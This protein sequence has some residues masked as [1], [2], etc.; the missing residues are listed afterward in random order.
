MNRS[1][2]SFHHVA[3]APSGID[4][5][6]AE[7]DTTSRDS[8]V[9][10]TLDENT[11]LCFSSLSSE[12]QGHLAIESMEI[13]DST[14]KRSS[15]GIPFGRQNSCNKGL[16]NETCTTPKVSR[17][18]T[19]SLTVRSSN[20][21]NGTRK[22]SMADAGTGDEEYQ[23]KRERSSDHYHLE[24]TGESAEDDYEKLGGDEVMAEPMFEDYPLGQESTSATT[25]AYVAF[26][27]PAQPKRKAATGSLV[28]HHTV[29]NVR[30]DD[31][32][33]E[34]LDEHHLRV[35]YHLPTTQ[36]NCST[37]F[38]R[39]GAK[40]MINVLTSMTEEAFLKKFI[41]IDCRYPF[42]YQAGH[43]KH[44][45]N[46]YDPEYV[47][48]M[49]YSSPHHKL[50]DRIPIFYCEFSQ[51]RGPS[52]ANALRK[53]DRNLNFH[54]YPRCSFEEMY[55]L[56]KG[57]REFHRITTLNKVTNLC[58]PRHAYVEMN[59]HRYSD[60]LRTYQQHKRLPNATVRRFVEP[61]STLSLTGKHPVTI[62]RPLSDGVPEEEQEPENPADRQA[63]L[64][65]QPDRTPQMPRQISR[66]ALTF[67]AQ[68][69]PTNFNRPRPDGA[70]DSPSPSKPAA[71]PTF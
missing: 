19:G 32:G 8:G 67:D 26:A 44:A 60:L 50:H 69:S 1:H 6:M 9:S 46:F 40:T 57:Y 62:A 33:N 42:E 71:C 68:D 37:S 35:Q 63:R 38:R 58:E 21:E 14:P 18:S 4:I 55:V 53:L 36:S 24:P 13:D 70:P 34:D 49:F 66:R 27:L 11:P 2:I 56:D 41:L 51:K 22:R 3:S 39:I 43:I 48:N 59:D 16:F 65:A 30:L 5:M 10:M 29:P 52:M 20:Q 12:M 28:H 64:Q 15:K 45:I 7:D 17:D 61:A 31:D 23:Q 47:F 54:H 25:S